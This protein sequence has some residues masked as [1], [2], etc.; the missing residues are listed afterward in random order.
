[1]LQILDGAL[2]AVGDGDGLAALVRR[3]SGSRVDLLLRG[4]AV[5]YLAQAGAGELREAVA[6]LFYVREEAAARGLPPEQLQAGEP[7]ARETIPQ[8]LGHYDQVW[9]F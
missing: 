4:D 1:V 5:R 7:I 6:S 2:G 3:G 9:H 8:L